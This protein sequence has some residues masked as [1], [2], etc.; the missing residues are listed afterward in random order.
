MCVRVCECVCELD[1]VCVCECDSNKDR[2]SVCVCVC[3]CV[4]VFVDVLY[5]MYVCASPND[6]SH[7][8][9]LARP[10]RELPGV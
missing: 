8:N 5:T 7:K 10:E 3:I 4:P 9:I 6:V 1:C 2:G